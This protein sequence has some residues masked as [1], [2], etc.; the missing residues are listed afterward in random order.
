MFLWRFALLQL[1]PFHTIRPTSVRHI[2]GVVDLEVVE[3]LSAR[4][5]AIVS[6]DGMI[7]ADLGFP[8]HI[9]FVSANTRKCHDRSLPSPIR[10]VYSYS[11]KSIALSGSS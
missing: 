8:Y 11:R 6:P 2:D 5:T 10:S 7:Q 9:G 1:L 3:F 4:R